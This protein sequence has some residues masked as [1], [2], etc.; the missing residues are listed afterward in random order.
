MGW[1]LKINA[2][3][4]AV[5]LDHTFGGI[6]DGSWTQASNLS[7]DSQGKITISGYTDSNTGTFQGLSYGQEDAFMLKI[8]PTTLG[9]NESTTNL[10]VTIYPNPVNTI[11]SIKTDDKMIVKKITIMDT[12][13]KVVL[14]KT[15]SF[16][17]INVENL[18]SGLYLLQITTEN[19]QIIT[20]KFLKQ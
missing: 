13:G 11:L 3:N 16:E 14:Q 5:L 8:D 19:N 10:A 17:T 4:G 6:D 7:I 9:I 1:L 15:N 2:T 12:M 20:Q 18:N